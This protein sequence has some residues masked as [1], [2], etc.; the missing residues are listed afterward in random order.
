M[1]TRD[2]AAIETA[3]R[4]GLSSVHA[5]GVPVI[6]TADFVDEVRLRSGNADYG[7]E[8]NAGV[9]AARTLRTDNGPL[10]VVDADKVTTAEMLERLVAHEG[11]HAIQ[12]SKSSEDYSAVGGSLDELLLFGI[13][14]SSME[15]FIAEREALKAGYRP[16]AWASHDDLLECLEVG[17][18]FPMVNAV[19][20]APDRDDVELLVNRV[21]TVLRDLSRALAYASAATLAGMA[22]LP[23]DGGE[24]KDEWDDY[25]A[26]TWD[27]RLDFYRDLPELA[28]YGDGEPWPEL[29]VVAMELDRELLRDLGFEFR[30][31]NGFFRTGSDEVFDR[32]VRRAQTALERR[33][34]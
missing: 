21:A 23:P 6:Y 8:R 20:V 27:L 4:R 22:N 7:A 14:G 33:S 18:N 17:V 31:A 2:A 10:I 3:I 24:L 30:G 25:V 1:G 12:Y 16:F 32:R 28:K 26:G 5:D 9:A 15:E 29:R 34:C 11:V 19:C 13:A